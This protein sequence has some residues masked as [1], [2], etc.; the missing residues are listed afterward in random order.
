MKLAKAIKY[1]NVGTVSLQRSKFKV[2]DSQDIK[3]F[4]SILKPS[5]VITDKV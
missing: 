1:F 4:E 2:I 5:Q 3:Y